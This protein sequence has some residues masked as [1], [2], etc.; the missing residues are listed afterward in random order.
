MDRL[1]LR[2]LG[3]DGVQEANELL[4]AVALHVAADDGALEDIE[5]GEQRRRAVVL[6][7]VGHRPGPAPLHGQARLGTIERLD[8]ALL[9]DRENDSV[10]RRIDVEPTMSRSLATNCGSVESLNCL[11]R[12][13]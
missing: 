7:V 11:T 5:S 2:H 10:G 1:L 4:M 9:V 3:L 12:C 8:L 13:G 6:V